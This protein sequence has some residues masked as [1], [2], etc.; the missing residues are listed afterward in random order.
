[1]VA[2]ERPPDWLRE[3]TADPHEYR[4]RLLIDTGRGLGF[5]DDVADDWQE[6]DF[7]AM[8]S[9]WRRALGYDEPDGFL[10]AYLER[11]RGHSKTTD[12]AIQ[13]SWALI[14][15]TRELYGR[16]RQLYGVVAAGDRDQA[17]LVRDAIQKLVFD[18]PWLAKILHVQNYRVVNH[19]THS[20]LDILASDVATDYGLTPDFL[21]CDELTHWEKSEMW[22]AMFSSVAKRPLC[23]G[24]I[25]SN[26]G[27]GEGSS[28]QWKVREMARTLD[29]WYFSRIDG[30]KASW[31]SEEQLAEQ[32]LALPPSSYR[33]LFDNLWVPGSGDAINPADIEAAMTLDGPP[34]YADQRGSVIHLAGLDLGMKHDHTG[35]V[36]AAI[37]V[38][39]GRVQMVECRS[40][41]PQAYG[42]IVPLQAVEDAVFDS[43]KKWSTA[44]TYYDP[45]ECEFMAQ[46]LRNR[47]VTMEE[48]LFVG[49][50][51][52][53]MA[54][55]LLQAFT[56]RIID[57]WPNEDLKRDLMR[58]T[59]VEKMYG[60]KLESV[61]DEYGHADRATALA[62][63][64]PGALEAAGYDTKL[65]GE[66]VGGTIGG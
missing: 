17:R 54:S 37:E 61:S 12:I 20:I 7:K 8:D 46:R 19:Y 27:I 56:R 9:G 32:R 6:A 3:A 60:Y 24:I 55:A 30:V 45:H 21:I 15:S 65:M 64:L 5:Y 31:M 22:D 16:T 35:F 33:R 14:A 58:V 2:A 34:R 38:G 28:W 49:K 53:G 43:A 36:T 50:Q 48:V 44:I 66:S 41:K 63:L 57:L 25:I 13:A 52:T 59:I 1:M 51:L 42:G 23:L 62:L 10:R 39:A 40:W 11:P 4:R 26:A 18:N 47:G 29:S